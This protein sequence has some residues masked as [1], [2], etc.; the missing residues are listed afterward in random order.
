MADWLVQIPGPQFLVFYIV[1]CVIG[2]A[3][4]WLFTCHRDFPL[5]DL[6]NVDPLAFAV[7]R[8]NWQAAIDVTIVQLMERG[9]VGIK[10]IRNIKVLYIMK[11]ETEL[12]ELEK[13]ICNYLRQPKSLFD[14]ESQEIKSKVIQCLQPV[15]RDLEKQHLWKNSE[16]LRSGKLVAL[17]LLL[18]LELFAALKVDL[19]LMYNK[20]VGFLLVMMLLL[21]FGVFLI[22]QPFKARTRFGNSYIKKVTVHFNWLADRFTQPDSKNSA[23]LDSALGVAIFGVSILAFTGGFGGYQAFAQSSYDALARSSSNYNSG[24][25]DSGSSSIDS[26]GS[27]GGGCGGG[28]GGCGGS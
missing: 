4:C 8:G 1:L 18:G 28:C 3:V 5:P 10:E 24:T 23:A 9:I 26:G 16:E 15:Y 22:L 14:F 21:P 25:Y 11:V 27:N 19:G 20:P 7:L 17:I 2:T 12:S 6:N 13:V